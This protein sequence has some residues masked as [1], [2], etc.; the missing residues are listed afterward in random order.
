MSNRKKVFLIV[1]LFIVFITHESIF[2]EETS[3]DTVNK[4]YNVYNTHY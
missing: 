3:E 1:G 4:K 2:K